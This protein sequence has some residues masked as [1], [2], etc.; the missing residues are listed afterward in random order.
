[1][2]NKYCDIIITK[3][4]NIGLKCGQV[5]KKCRHRINTCNICK[6]SYTTDTSF[7]NH[8]KICK[9]TKTK[10]HIK[11]KDSCGILCGDVLK[12]QNNEDDLKK[13]VDE[14]VEKKLQSMDD[15]EK[16]IIINNINS[17]NTTVNINLTTIGCADGLQRLIDKMGKDGAMR[18]LVEIT[19]SGN[20]QLMS[21]MEKLYLTGDPTNYPIAN[22]DGNIFRFRD[23]D[24]RIIHDIGGKK[25]A[26]LSTTIHSNIYAGAANMEAFRFIENG[27]N[28]DCNN[29]YVMQEN[30]SNKHNTC[31]FIKD[32]AYRTF[33]PE[34]QF[35]TKGTP[36]VIDD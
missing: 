36:V 34:H 27:D 4:K 24:Q 6:N 9:P 11:L 5:N 17:N 14:L 19:A 22:K 13:R 3:G 16:T 7:S 30:A 33:N 21:L 26:K 15:G 31:T 28:D 25:I 32:L 29:Y 23:I 12:K 35:F 2:D 20:N 18:F 1:M 10:P 8:Q